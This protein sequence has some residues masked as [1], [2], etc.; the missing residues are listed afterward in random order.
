MLNNMFGHNNFPFGGF[1]NLF[2]KMLSPEEMINKKPGPN[3]NLHAVAVRSSSGFD[4]DGKRTG[5][6]VIVI[7][8]NGD[9]ETIESKLK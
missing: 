7:N 6:S 4:K 9:V 5:G 1:N 8:D 3:Q 2:P